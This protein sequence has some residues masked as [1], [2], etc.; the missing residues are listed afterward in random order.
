MKIDLHMKFNNGR[1]DEAFSYYEKVFGTKRI[2]TMKFSEM[3]EQNEMTKKSPDAIMHT[4]MNVGNVTLMGCDA[5]LGTVTH[6]GIAVA[7]SDPDEEKLKTW[8]AALSEGGEVEMPLGPTFWSPLFGM[9]T[10]KF[11]V[12]WMIGAPGQQPE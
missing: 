12:E 11:G 6:T 9:C 1:C 4:A 2:F 5:L 10:D 8:F 3:P 7:L